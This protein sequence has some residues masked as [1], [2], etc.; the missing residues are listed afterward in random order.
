[1]KKAIKTLKAL[2]SVK[3]G[4]SILKSNF[5]VLCLVM[6]TGAANAQK[7]HCTATTKKGQPCKAWAM[8]NTT[9]CRVHNKAV[10]ATP[11]TGA[12]CAATAKSTGKPCK[13]HVKV[14]GDKCKQH[15]G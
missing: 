4:Y 13:H 9:V 2:L 5:V 12:T 1:M 15:G 8:A 14:T 10:A 7:A 3:N 6:V 11:Y